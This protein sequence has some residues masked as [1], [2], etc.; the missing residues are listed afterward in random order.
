MYH[1]GRRENEYPGI[2]SSLSHKKE[3]HLGLEGRGGGWWHRASE[4]GDKSGILSK[5][6]YIIKTWAVHSGCKEINL[7]GMASEVREENQ[8]CSQEPDIG[9]TWKVKLSGLD[10]SHDRFLGK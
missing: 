6:D 4:S 5:P 2:T 3:A 8:M 10:L 7:S 1:C 9:W